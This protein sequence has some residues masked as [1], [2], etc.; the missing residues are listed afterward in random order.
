MAQ[1]MATSFQLS[2]VS[3]TLSA[4][5]ATLNPGL[6]AHAAL[7]VPIR[8][9]SPTC[10]PSFAATRSPFLSSPLS[11]SS[12]RQTVPCRRSRNASRPAV[13]A[14]VTESP[15]QDLATANVETELDGLFEGLSWTDKT[16][17]SL[18]AAITPMLLAEVST[19]Y[20]FQN[21]QCWFCPAK[22]NIESI[23]RLPV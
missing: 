23:D 15:G 20:C 6:S 4:K 19:W 5:A 13:V 16:I 1:A 7:P 8:A 11:G 22:E 12:F 3:C 9:S 17:L 2:Q 14:Q 10:T 18:A 21:M